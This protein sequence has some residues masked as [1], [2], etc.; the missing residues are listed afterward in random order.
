V[1]TADRAA[2]LALTLACVVAC[3]SPGTSP[4]DGGDIKVY[5]PTFPVPDT[6][7][8]PPSG[9]TP[10]AGSYVY[11]EGGASLATGVSFPRTIALANGPIAATTTRQHLVVTA[12]DTVDA[13]T[14][15]G[16]FEAM[17]GMTVLEVGYYP[18]LRGPAEAL[19]LGGAIDVSLNGRRCSKLTGW[20]AIDH[21]FYFNGNMTMLDLRFEQ[22]CDGDAVPMHGQVHWRE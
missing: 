19:P 14:M 11:L 17:L 18:E 7:W 16:S 2:A 20:F 5:R 9:A 3:G 8:K 1:A 6:L 10:A 21:V 15:Q 4:Y 13:L 12:T 22:R